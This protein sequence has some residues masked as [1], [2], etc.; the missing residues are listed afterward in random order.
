M[1][2]SRRDFLG[3]STLLTAACVA[4]GSLLGGSVAAS[5]LGATSGDA[6]AAVKQHTDGTYDTVPLAKPAW[7]LCLAQTPVHSFDA[8][9]WRKGISGNLQH[10]LQVIDAAHYMQKPDLI[11]FHEFPLSGWRNWSR[12]EILKFAIEIPGEETAA[13][14]AKARHY[15]TWIVFGAYARDKDWP[16]HVLSITTI[17]NDKGEIVA[18]QWKARNTIVSGFWP[19][20]ELFTTTI[21]NVLD[22]YVEMYGR[23]AVI[24]V[25][26]TP[27]G[28]LATSSTQSEPELF[29]AMAIKGAEVFLR[30]ASGGFSKTDI[31]ACA[32]YNGVYSSIVNNSISPD[33]GPFLEDATG[34]TGGTAIY[35]PRGEVVAEAGSPNETFVWGYIPIGQLRA[36]HR[37]PKLCADLYRDVYADY[38]APYAPGLFTQHQPDTME[39]AY[40]YLKDKSRWK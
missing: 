11:Q 29:R 3:N 4:G 15:G 21:D 12:Q 10:M 31:A 34:M 23:D 19:G 17:I 38:V 33:N 35:G 18:R 7:T 1:S 8:S 27:L 26:R 13:I 32:S 20:K 39:D 16:G 30:T 40:R 5:T 37:Q 14:A 28:N 9:Q 22:R 2:G 24:P 36:R 6:A 25:A